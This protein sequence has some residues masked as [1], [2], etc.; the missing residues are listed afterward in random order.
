MKRAIVAY[1]SIDS[2]LLVVPNH[3]YQIR[4][5]PITKE[6]GRDDIDMMN[7]Q[8]SCCNEKPKLSKVMCLCTD[9]S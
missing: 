4:I 9:V 8:H 6:D 1:I 2:H 7:E 5:C 3:H